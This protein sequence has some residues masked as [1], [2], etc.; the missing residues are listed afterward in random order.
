MSV[1]VRTVIPMRPLASALP[2]LAGVA[3]PAQRAAL[4]LWLLRVVLRA[5][6]NHRAGPVVVLGGDAPCAIATSGL[7][8]LWRP[9]PPEGL[10]AWLAAAAAAGEQ[11][12]GLLVLRPD[13]PLVRVSDLSALLAAFDGGNAVA[14]PGPD[15]RLQALVAPPGAL[16]GVAAAPDCAEGWAAHLNARGV[17]LRTMETP[18]LALALRKPADLAAAAARVPNLWLRTAGAAARLSRWERR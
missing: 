3:S 14:A 12:S 7:G 15:G 17:P 8:A 10:P 9:G 18:G 16:A 6:V 11:L 1:R 2:G 5:A 13:L 4:A